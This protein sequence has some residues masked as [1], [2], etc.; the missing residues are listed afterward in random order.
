MVPLSAFIIIVAIAALEVDRVRIE[1]TADGLQILL[2]PLVHASP[3]TTLVADVGIEPTSLGYERGP[4]PLS[5]SSYPHY[6]YISF[7]GGISNVLKRSDKHGSHSLKFTIS[8]SFRWVSY[9]S[10]EYVK[11]PVKNSATSP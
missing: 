11:Y 7:S 10:R 1:L 3:F 6:K 9:P 4:K 5:Q 2:A 8:P